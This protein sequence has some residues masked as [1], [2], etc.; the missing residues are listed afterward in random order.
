MGRGQGFRSLS[1][2]AGEGRFHVLCQLAELQERAAAA[3]WEYVTSDGQ[4]DSTRVPL[5]DAARAIE[6]LLSLIGDGSEAEEETAQ[7]SCDREG[8]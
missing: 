2:S 4:E 6:N 5:K 1:D 8:R 7:C 3:T